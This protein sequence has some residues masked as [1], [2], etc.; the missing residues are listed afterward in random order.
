MTIVFD[1]DKTL[2]YED[3]LLGFYKIVNKNDLIFS[4]K[5]LLLL[6]AAI[7]Y[8]FKLINNDTLKKFGIFLFLKGKEKN[9]IKQKSKE[10]SKKIK[11]NKIYNNDFQLYNK[12][13]I[14][15]VSASFEDY[16]KPIFPD[17]NILS[18]KIDYTINDKVKGLKKNVYSSVKNKE[19]LK[20]GIDHI[21]ILYT[22][23]F[24]DKP[25]MDIADKV[26]LI[27]NGNKRLIK[28]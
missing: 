25:L 21:D 8:K 1:F 24:S 13:D 18:S 10:Y 7:V 28:G 4:I 17:I 9:T 20:H 3:T 19:L 14:I 2:T 15:L 5:R 27:K 22:D 16:L 12:D 26:F 23:S 6:I 11:L